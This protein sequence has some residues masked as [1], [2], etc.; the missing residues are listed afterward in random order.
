MTLRI[1]RIVASTLN[2]LNSTMF[3]HLYLEALDDSS[4]EAALHAVRLDHDVALLFR[5][6]R[7]RRRRARRCHPVTRSS[8]GRTLCILVRDRRESG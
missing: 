8:H 1:Q 3:F 4:D 6:R 7:H 5:R 2:P